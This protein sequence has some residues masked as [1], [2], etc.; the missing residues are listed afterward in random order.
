MCGKEGHDFVVTKKDQVRFE[1]AFD[2]LRPDLEDQ[3]DCETLIDSLMPMNLPPGAVCRIAYLADANKDGKLERDEFFAGMHLALRKLH[4]LE[5]PMHLPLR[6]APPL[7]RKKQT[8]T[9][10]RRMTELGEEELPKLYYAD[11]HPAPVCPVIAPP[12]EPPPPPPKPAPM[13][14]WGSLFGPPVRRKKIIPGD[15]DSLLE[16]GDNVLQ[17]FAAAKKK[18]RDVRI[19]EDYYLTYGGARATGSF[20]HIF[21]YL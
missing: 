14:D 2:A 19:Q 15:V 10:Y 11:E 5:L 7:K 20:S 9:A 6:M 18:F 8:E 13:L 16:G 4:G 21:S 3:I 12:S 17:L 1:K